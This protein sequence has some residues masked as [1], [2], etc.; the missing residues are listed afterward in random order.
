[1]RICPCTDL[2]LHSDSDV[3]P[4]MVMVTLGIWIQWECEI[5]IKSTLQLD[6]CNGHMF[7]GQIFALKWLRVTK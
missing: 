5:A 6:E 2:I 3:Q 1:M 4:P 7:Q